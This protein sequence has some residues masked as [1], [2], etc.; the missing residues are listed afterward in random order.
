[1]N[2]TVASSPSATVS[3][4]Q[5]DSQ[6]ISLAKAEV[7]AAAKIKVQSL[8]FYYGSHQVL[9]DNHLEIARNKVTA[10]IGPSGCGK[11]THLRVYNRIYELYRDQK[12]TGEVWLDDQN[13]LAPGIDL[14]ELRRRVGM[15]FQKLPPSR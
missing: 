4:P 14:L 5:L 2:G 8:N 10:V 1:M 15:I 7:L 11:S 9:F 12:A 6:A 3:L 13:I